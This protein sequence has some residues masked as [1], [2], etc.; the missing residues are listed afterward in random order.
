MRSGSFAKGLSIP[1][2]IGNFKQ[3]RDQLLLNSASA[4][5]PRDRPG[6]RTAGPPFPPLRPRCCRADVCEAGA[7]E[8]VG[9]PIA[10]QSRK[11]GKLALAEPGRRRC[12]CEAQQSVRSWLRQ[13]SQGRS[14]SRRH[15]KAMLRQVCPDAP[16]GLGT[17]CFRHSESF[18]GVLRATDPGRSINGGAFA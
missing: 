8:W 3:L 7:C 17:V 18:R 1:E 5:H 13:A 14:A 2:A 10:R 11:R 9:A 15:V 12:C 6:W 16:D 4:V